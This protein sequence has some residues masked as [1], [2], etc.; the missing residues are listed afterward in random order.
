MSRH[1][2][3]GLPENTMERMLE[4]LDLTIPA[5]RTL[6]IHDARGTT[7]R[8][9]EGCAWITEYANADDYVLEAGDARRVAGNG[10]TLVHAFKA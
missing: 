6:R 4:T 1:R 8:V 10:L 5:G 7:L 3:R 2:A 9:T